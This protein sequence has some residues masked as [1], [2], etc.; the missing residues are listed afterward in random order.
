[1]KKIKPGKLMSDILKM[2]KE[3]KDGDYM[4]GKAEDYSRKA[5][6]LEPSRLISFECDFSTFS[7]SDD[8]PLGRFAFY[9]DAGR[10]SASKSLRCGGDGG[11]RAEFASSDE[12]LMRL[13]ELIKELDLESHNG[14]QYFVNGLPDDFGYRL[15]IKYESGNVGA[16]NNQSNHLSVKAI[17]A[18]VRFFESSAGVDSSFE[19]ADEYYD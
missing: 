13:A 5:A 4:P 11:Y 12:L 2:F 6:R 14:E 17:N 8:V 3:S 19:A 15:Y 16:S 1:M 9:L 7:R 10:G 18:L